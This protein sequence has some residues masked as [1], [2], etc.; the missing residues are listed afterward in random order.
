ERQFDVLYGADW[1]CLHGTLFTE[2]YQRDSLPASARAQQSN[3]LLTFGGSNFDTPYGSP[4]TII[5][6]GRSWAIPVSQS[7]ATPTSGGLKPNTENLKPNTENLYDQYLR[8]DALPGERKLSFLGGARQD[9]DDGTHLSIDLL[10]VDRQVNFASP[11]Q[12][13]AL[14]VPVSN[15]F[16][17]NPTGG[18]APVTV[19]YGFLSDLGPK[20][21]R[22]DVRSGDLALSAQWPLGTH[23]ALRAT[24]V[25][26]IDKQQRRDSGV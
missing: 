8:T 22:V 24:G 16:Y 21:S 26:A 7:G 19:L 3:D 12:G 2:C 17:I 15:P 10:V 23:W 25:S 6:D 9:F 20:E 11:A 5:Q 18:T 14:T 4:G 13:I 1:E